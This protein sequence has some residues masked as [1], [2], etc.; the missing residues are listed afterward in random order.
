M[1]AKAEVRPRP[2]PL[3]VEAIKSFVAT[4]FGKELRDLKLDVLG[5]DDSPI[6]ITGQR[7]L[8][9][10]L[11]PC[12]IDLGREKVIDYVRRILAVGLLELEAVY[13]RNVA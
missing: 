7:P 3:K 4:A 11:S 10:P 1:A 9:H 12:S 8:P 5:T 2:R 6:P 13:G